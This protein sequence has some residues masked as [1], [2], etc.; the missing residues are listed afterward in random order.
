MKTICIIVES[1]PNDLSGRLVKVYM[2]NQNVVLI[3][4]KGS[5]DFEL[6]QLA[7]EM[8]NLCVAYSVKLEVEWIPRNMNSLADELSTI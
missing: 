3:A 8:F 7:L 5:M 6:H 1:L 4:C 2:D